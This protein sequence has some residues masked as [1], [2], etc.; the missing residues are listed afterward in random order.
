[1]DRLSTFLSDL[2]VLSLSLGVG[3]GPFCD[4]VLG[5]CCLLDFRIIIT[6]LSKWRVEKIDCD[7]K[8]TYGLLHV[9]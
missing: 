6:N 2:I 3:A 4:P 1:M 9:C 7:A 5:V 8:F